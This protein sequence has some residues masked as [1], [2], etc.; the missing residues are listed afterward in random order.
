MNQPGGWIEISPVTSLLR[1]CWIGAGLS[2]CAN[3]SQCLPT[4]SSQNDATLRAFT[5]PAI[6]SGFVKSGLPI[7]WARRIL[8]HAAFKGAIKRLVI[9]ELA[10]FRLLTYL[11]WAR[12]FRSGIIAVAQNRNL[13]GSPANLE[14]F[15]FRLK[16]SLSFGSSLRIRLG[17]SIRAM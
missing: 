10:P 9:L 16:G 6:C 5:A 17:R 15:R 11:N 12:R 7:R 4:F 8:R 14:S 1:A 3:G 13:I 2:Q